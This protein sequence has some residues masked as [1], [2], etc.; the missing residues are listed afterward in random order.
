MRPLALLTFL[1]APALLAA[2]CDLNVRAVPADAPTSIEWNKYLGARSYLVTESPDDFVTTKSYEVP[3][4]SFTIPHRVSEATKFSYRVEAMFDPEEVIDGACHGALSLTMQ[5]DPEFRKMTRKVIVPIVGSVSRFRTWLRITSNAA[6]QRGRIVFHPAGVAS[7][8]DPSMRYEFS[9]IRQSFSWDDIVATLGASGVGSLDIIP[10][11]DSEAAPPSVLARHY[12]DASTGTFGSFEPA[13][14]PFD[15]LNASPFTLGA[16]D[17]RFR[18][19]LGFRTLTATTVSA[20]IFDATGHVRALKTVG[21][22][23]DYFTLFPASQFVGTIAPGET[24][25]LSFAGSVIPFYTL[26][27]NGTND[28]AVVIPRPA[29]SRFIE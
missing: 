13:V 7:D 14:V 19:N 17:P 2:P 12:T 9:G 20:L 23:A 15:F 22:P 28:P 5:P 21:Y 27:E 25:T 18:L 24:F 3:A 29:P 4:T 10:D 1:L 26:T 6:G 11:D 8:S 16:T